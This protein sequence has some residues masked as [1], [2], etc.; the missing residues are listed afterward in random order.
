MKSYNFLEI[1]ISIAAR[2]GLR[3]I[4]LHNSRR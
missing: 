1:T 3:T 4:Y 2:I